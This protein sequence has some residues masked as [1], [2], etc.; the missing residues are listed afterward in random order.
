MQ[1]VEG[2]EGITD[3]NLSRTAGA[4]EDLVIIDR[5]KAARLGLSVQTIAQMLETVLSGT[6]AGELQEAG[7]EYPLIVRIDAAE[8]LP[9]M[10]LLDL[11]LTNSSGVPIVLRNVVSVESSGKQHRDRADRSGTH[12]RCI[13]EP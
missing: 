3:V 1:A 4:P 7:R 11:T 5:I 10:E 12:D 6:Q 2:V 8:F 9:I 13:R